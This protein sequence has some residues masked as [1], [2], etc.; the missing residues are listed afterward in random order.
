L[1]EHVTENHG[2]G[3][4]IPPLGTITPSQG[5][6]YQ[7]PAPNSD[8][9]S[10]TPSGDQTG[11]GDVEVSV[12]PSAGASLDVLASVT[13]E[14]SGGVALGTRETGTMTIQGAAESLAESF[15]GFLSKMFDG[16]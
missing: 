8:G 4:S 10:A 12:D 11:T 6:T 2:V 5:S 14:V 15:V 16:R 13:V 3:G 7:E 1:V 9:T